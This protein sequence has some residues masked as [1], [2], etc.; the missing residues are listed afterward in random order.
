MELDIL[1]KIIIGIISSLGTAG[2]MFLNFRQAA[3]LKAELLEKLDSAVRNN[4]KHTATELFRLIHGVRMSFADV[5]ALIQHDECSKII[6]ALKK[7]PGIVAYKSG[8]F[9]YS[10]LGKNTLYRFIDRWITKI[11]LFIFSTLSVVFVLVFSFGHGKTSITGFIMMIIF[12]AL[13]T[14]QLKQRRYD[15]MIDNLV[16]TAPNK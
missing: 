16:N 1:T 6:Y 11:G 12:T 5:K 2:V 7:T 10:G 8:N 4:K 13:T 15:R 9:E 14:A 3:K